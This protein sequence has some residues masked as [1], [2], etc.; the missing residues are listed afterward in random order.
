VAVLRHFDLVVLVIALPVFIVA[1]LPALGYVTGAGAWAMWKGIG[2][3]TRRRAAA[4]SDPRSVAGW[5]VGSMVGRGWALGLTIVAIGLANRDAGLSGAVLVFVLFTV[6][7][8]VQMILRP[9]ETT[10]GPR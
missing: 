3:Y 4:T 5:M 8:S 10:P 2:I 6:N 1:G 9:F 7:L